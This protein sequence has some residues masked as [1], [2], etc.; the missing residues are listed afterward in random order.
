MSNVI[1][2]CVLDQT[3]KNSAVQSL[4]TTIDQSAS[5][6]TDGFSIWALVILAI[7]KSNPYRSVL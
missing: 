3:N 6:K 5:A 2:K 1:S 4:Q 7:L